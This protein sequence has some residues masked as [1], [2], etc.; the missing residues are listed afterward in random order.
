MEYNFW[1]FFISSDKRNL[2]QFY[3]ELTVSWKYLGDT[4]TLH[5]Y[6]Y[7]TL[8]NWLSKDFYF[9]Y[10]KYK[11]MAIG[12]VM[13]LKNKENTR[14]VTDVPH[15]GILFLF[16]QECGMVTDFKI[17]IYFWCHCGFT[18][19]SVC[20]SY[21]VRKSILAV[22]TSAIALRPLHN[23]INFF[24]IIFIWWLLCQLGVNAWQITCCC[25][26]VRI[27]LHKK[28]LEQDFK[29][30]FFLHFSFPVSYSKL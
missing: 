18:L 9:F 23:R 3:P 7:Y 1:E 19:V 12:F 11:Q 29:L 5:A 17:I 13:L 15:R 28:L 14:S 25:N 4:F 26:A 10:T 2:S 24:K 6:C 21:C 8:W 20:L 16:Y 22:K 30:N 27:S